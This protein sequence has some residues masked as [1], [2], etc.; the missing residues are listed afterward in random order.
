[1][2]RRG[3][4][5]TDPHRSGHRPHQRTRPRYLAPSGAVR[6]GAATGPSSDHLCTHQVVAVERTTQHR[7]AASTTS[8]LVMRCAPSAG[9]RPP[10]GVL[11]TVRGCGCI[12][13]SRWC[14][15]AQVSAFSTRRRRSPSVKMPST[16]CS[17]G[18]DHGDRTQPLGAHLAHHVA[19]TG[20]LPMRGTC[21]TGAH[22]V[23][24]MGQQLAP[25]RTAGMRAGKVFG[26]EN[27]AHPAGHS[28][29]RRPWPV[30]RWCWRSAPG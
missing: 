8:T 3:L 17:L 25:Q 22:H 9:Q 26:L 28:Q 29:A 10:P 19:Q 12:T 7:P 11:A 15:C 6:A 24:H 18:V 13:C 16:M 1:V 30:A 23:A 27:R 2:S 14:Q 21:I 20:V 4:T 5:D